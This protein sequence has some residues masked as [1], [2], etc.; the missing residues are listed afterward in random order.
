MSVVPCTRWL[1]VALEIGDGVYRGPADE[2][3][4]EIR[5]DQRLAAKAA[6]FDA[7]HQEQTP[8]GWIARRPR[9]ETVRL[10]GHELVESITA[11]EFGP[12]LKSRST[13]DK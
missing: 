1:S 12:Q 11:T 7:P 6:G 9:Y 10:N 8:S 2:S 4:A 3:R 13:A 5:L